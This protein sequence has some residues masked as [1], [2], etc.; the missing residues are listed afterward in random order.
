ML[1]KTEEGGHWKVD[2]WVEVNYHIFTKKFADVVLMVD[3]DIR[4]GVRRVVRVVR[5]R[6][7]TAPPTINKMLNGL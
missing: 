4:V 1:R 6:Y 7:C 5:I 3:A 2:G